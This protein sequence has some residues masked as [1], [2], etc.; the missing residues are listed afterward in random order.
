MA[1]SIRTRNVVTPRPQNL[2]VGGK[3]VITAVSNSVGA[4]AT[5]NTGQWTGPRQTF[6]YNWY[7]SA[8]TVTNATNASFSYQ[9]AGTH[10]CLVTVTNPY[11]SKAVASAPITIL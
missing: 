3:P 5:V 4:I 6:A 9:S 7:R 8:A 1:Y 2:G 10:T 11:G